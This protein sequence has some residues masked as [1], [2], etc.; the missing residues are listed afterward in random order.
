MAVLNISDFSGMLPIKD[1]TLLP[2]NYAQEC[3]N[4]FLY[5]GG[6]RGFRISQ[7]VFTLVRPSTSKQVYRIPLNDNIED[8]TNSVWLEF[9]DPFMSVLRNPTVGDQY[10]R[11]Y[12]FP[13]D[14]FV[15]DGGPWMNV[16]FYAPLSNIQ[17][18]GPFY[19]LGITAP[20]TAPLVHAPLTSGSLG[21]SA[22]S[23]VG[24]TTLNFIN[25]PAVSVG[26][27]VA[28]VTVPA[29][30]LSGTAV[31]APVTA[32]VV[33]INNPVAAPGVGTGDAITFTDLAE[34]RS[35]VYTYVSAY[36]E[37]GPPSPP[38]LGTGGTSGNWK[39]TVY[40]PSASDLLNR[41]LAYIRI[42]R[43][44]TDASGNATFY[45]VVQLP[46]STTPGA[47]IVY[48][49]QNSPTVIT[50]N[51][52]LPSVLYTGPPAGLQGVVMMA[53]GIMAGWTN[54]RE[55]WFSGAFIP[56]AWPA[57]YALTVDFPTVGLA[58]VGSSLSVMTQGQPF[59]ATGVTPDTM[60]IGK[61]T[62]N[63]PCISR[64]SIFPAGEGVY[65]ASPFGLILVNTS[66]T[67]NTT[68]MFMEREFWN[69]L[70]P[71]TWAAGR[72]GLSYI[73]VF[74]GVTP[75]NNNG[76]NGCVI[77]FLEK[78][79]PMSFLESAV[80]P[81]DNL[82]WDQLSGQIFIITQGVVRWLN[83]PSGGTLL[84]W[85]WISK[86][87]RLPKPAQ[88]K[89]FKVDFSVPPEV[90]I[91]PPTAASRNNN[92]TQVFNPA[93]QYLTVTIY[94][95]LDSPVEDPDNPVVVR[96]V[97][98][99]GETILIPGGFKDDFWTIMFEGQVNVDLFKM[100]SSVKELSK[101]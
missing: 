43:T 3:S 21:T 18:G 5:R 23:A 81:I 77:D 91:P 2:D 19:V 28:D 17:A 88:F 9:P 98:T 12:F 52:I 24:A 56:H 46:I 73:A 97:V 7:P 67:I 90:T 38:T 94:R 33:T 84:P 31:I 11:Y 42:Y 78:N 59:I 93:T 64:G 83:P 87:Y 8:W 48:D 41:N 29:A 60:T 70:Q 40:S 25:T 35:Y 95:G 27:T 50:N 47:A 66:G 4:T 16:P 92:Q 57:T 69:S 55:I 22:P 36:D 72:L 58:A 44:V 1:P 53:N 30:L 45:Q 6:L 86:N 34:V 71:Q 62:A 96:E 15:A 75:A 14:K 76:H 49:D 79:V 99:S 26:M 20:T 54:D 10:N 32:T 82:F 85:Y 39:I 80:A 65:Y 74:T 101:S 61:V 100:A 51:V 89:A 13:S 68:Q 63:E 37:E